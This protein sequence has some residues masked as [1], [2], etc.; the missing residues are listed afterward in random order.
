[1]AKPFPHVVIDKLFSD[2]FLSQIVAE[3]PSPDSLMWIQY[4]EFHQRKLA[5]NGEEQLGT[6]TRMLL[7]YMNSGPFIRFLQELTGIE[8]LIPDPHLLGGGAHQIARGG[9]LSMHVDFNRHPELDLDRRL[10]VLLYLNRDWSDD[11]AGH[12]ELWNRDLS[13][14]VQRIAPVFN[15]LAVFSTTDYSWHGHPEPLNCPAS[16]TRK[17]LAL[18]YYT[19]GRPH[20][21]IESA[22]PKLTIW[23]LRPGEKRSLNL[24]EIVSRFIPPIVSDAV[25]LLKNAI[26][27]RGERKSK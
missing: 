21:E 6:L 26:E 3:F 12:L 9:R 22:R 4:K 19:N 24:M 1:M 8:G 20:G 5:S 17:S 13:A 25:L 14:C 10:N 11:Y 18:Y 15:R 16:M 2:K 27:R 7:H 23:R